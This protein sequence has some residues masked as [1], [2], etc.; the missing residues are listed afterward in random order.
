MAITILLMLL[1]F[2][3]SWGSGFLVAYDFVH[4]CAGMVEWDTFDIL[5]A[6]ESESVGLC[7]AFWCPSGSILELSGSSSNVSWTFVALSSFS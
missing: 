1:L 5:D 6:V 2:I 7:W 3:L 4:C